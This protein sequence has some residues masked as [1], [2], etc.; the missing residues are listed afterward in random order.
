VTAKGLE[1]LCRYIARPPLAKSRL[2]TREDGT[3]VIRL[4]QPWAASHHPSEALACLPPG[5]Q[6]T[7][8][9][10]T[11]VVLRTNPDPVTEHYY[12][13]FQVDTVFTTRELEAPW[14]HLRAQPS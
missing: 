10:K 12:L 11:L 8:H 3:V 4:K 14:G 6:M 9:P 7:L 13:A 1:R 5:R 2:V